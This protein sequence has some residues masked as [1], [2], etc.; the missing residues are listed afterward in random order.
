MKVRAIVRYGG[1]LFKEGQKWVT[2]SL[3]G[4]GIVTVVVSDRHMVPH[5]G[6]KLLTGDDQLSDKMR[7]ARKEAAE[8]L[9]DTKSTDRGH[10]AITASRM[11]LE[12]EEVPETET[13]ETPETK[14]SLNPNR[15]RA[16]RILRCGFSHK[17]NICCPVR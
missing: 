8:K 2:T 7:S 6:M 16:G 12:P 1:G 14:R 9:A 4:F 15:L 17:R 13:E 10:H 5:S 11:R 3:P